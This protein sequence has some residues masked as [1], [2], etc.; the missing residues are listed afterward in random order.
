MKTFMSMALVLWLAGLA[1]AAGPVHK[2]LAPPETRKQHH[3]MSVTERQWQ[4]CKKSMEAGDFTAAGT[5]LGRMKVA[6]TGLDK[7]KVHKHA[8]SMER[9][10]EQ[11]RAFK[12]DM[13]K[14]ADAIN[15][16]ENVHLQAISVRIEEGCLSCHS[17]FK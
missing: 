3:V 2:R 10:R 8:V 17:T 16:K 13:D 14:L 1:Q 15:K 12:G 6:L 11:S 5:A 4:A 7:F 9:F